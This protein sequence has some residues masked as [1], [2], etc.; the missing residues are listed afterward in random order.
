M[1]DPQQSFAMNDYDPND[2]MNDSS[3][4]IINVVTANTDPGPNAAASVQA[5][6]PAQPIPNIA[7]ISTLAGQHDLGTPGTNSHFTAT[8]NVNA[9]PGTNAPSYEMSAADIR[10]HILSNA[11]ASAPRLRERHDPNTTMILTR[12]TVMGGQL[13]Y[14]AVVSCDGG[15]FIQSAHAP[16][17][18]G[19]MIG[20]LNATMEVMDKH[21]SGYFFNAGHPGITFLAGSGGGVELH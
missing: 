17:L 19:A 6:G 12:T 9:G 8:A 3:Q 20:L 16:S 1:S 21:T 4:E 15:P 10:F 2:E 11:L 18:Q 14:Y 7:N 5:F 13:Q